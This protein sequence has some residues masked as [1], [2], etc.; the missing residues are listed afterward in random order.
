MVQQQKNKC[1][2]F[3]LYET[4]CTTIVMEHRGVGVCVWTSSPHSS[5]SPWVPIPCPCPGRWPRSPP[6]TNYCI[7]CRDTRDT[8][9]GQAGDWTR[10]IFIRTTIKYPILRR[11]HIFT[12]IGII[13]LNI[14]WCGTLLSLPHWLELLPPLLLL[15]FNPSTG[16]KLNRWNIVTVLHEYILDMEHENI[17]IF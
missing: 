14:G 9:A 17:D 8:S 5:L 3:Y 11:Q 12:G 4:P 6:P 1:R 7:R 13:L 15:P 2:Q 16:A 10:E